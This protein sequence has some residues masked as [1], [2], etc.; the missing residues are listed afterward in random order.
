MGS[1][2]FQSVGQWKQEFRGKKEVMGGGWGDKL[3]G[4]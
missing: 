2:V 4:C 3:W 1:G